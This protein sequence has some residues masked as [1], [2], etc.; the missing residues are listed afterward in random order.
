MHWSFNVKQRLGAFEYGLYLIILLFWLIW[1]TLSK[2]YLNGIIRWLQY[3]SEKTS[4]V[5]LTKWVSKDSLRISNEETEQVLRKVEKL[6]SK[7]S[8]LRSPSSVYYIMSLSWCAA[9]L[10]RYWFNLSSFKNETNLLYSYINL[11]GVFPCP[12]LLYFI[13]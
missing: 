11:Y 3:V 13:L 7:C 2:S 10:Y 9:E 12:H 5:C 6:W 1:F 4:V 8:E